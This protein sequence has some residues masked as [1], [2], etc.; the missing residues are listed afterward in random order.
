[1]PT[2]STPGQGF[3]L[4]RLSIFLRSSSTESKRFAGQSELA[5]PCHTYLGPSG[6]QVGVAVQEVLRESLLAVSSLASTQS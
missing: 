5:A 1:M 6:S 4:G 2:H 3:M